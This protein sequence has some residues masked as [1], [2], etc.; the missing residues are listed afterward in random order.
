LSPSVAGLGSE[1]RSPQSPGGSEKRGSVAARLT[2]LR[3]EVRSP[4][5]AEMKFSVAGRLAKTA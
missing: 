2:R 1:R 3:G 5:G 4:R